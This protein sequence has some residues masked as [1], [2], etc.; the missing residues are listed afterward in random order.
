MRRIGGFPY[1]GVLGVTA[2]GG[3]LVRVPR[4]P[5][6]GF[7]GRPHPDN[8]VDR[9]EG[10]R[11]TAV[12]SLGVMHL[13]ESVICI[14]SRTVDDVRQIGQNRRTSVRQINPVRDQ[15]VGPA[16]GRCQRDSGGFGGYKFRGFPHF[17]KATDNVRNGLLCHAEHLGNRVVTQPLP[18]LL[19]DRSVTLGLGLL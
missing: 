18:V 7:L 19:H 11:G 2:S 10:V 16:F 13:A 12:V 15:C 1:F 9:R 17:C 14:R 8:P 6:S 5:D 4:L 3:L